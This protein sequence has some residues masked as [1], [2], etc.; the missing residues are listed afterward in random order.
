MLRPKELDT[1]RWWDEAWTLVEGCTPVSA[2]CDHCWSEA[3]ARRFKKPWTPRFR[4]DRLTIPLRARKPRVY[5][6]WNDLF[7]EVVTNEQIAAALGVMAAEPQ[8]VFMVLTKRP[9]RL[10]AFMEW[11]DP[12]RYIEGA[13]PMS[14][15][16]VGVTV[17]SQEHIHRVDTLLE[18][19]PGLTFVSFE[20]MLGMCNWTGRKMPRVGLAICGGESGA[21]ARPMHP[22]WARRLRDDC[23][24][25]GVPYLFKQWGEWGP[26]SYPYP[27]VVHVEHD[28]AL[29]DSPTR[30][31]YSMRRV[32]RKRAGRKFFD[33]EHNGWFGGTK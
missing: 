10:D 28:G 27:G 12:L 22:N 20:P 16:A 9:E 24:D 30:T 11:H 32:G 31:S 15:V 13:W 8:H 19:W 23:R 3:M 1:G 26:H 4:A 33:V 5:A 6:V 21:G 2:G 14:N 7:H 29:L 17:E 18:A 25:A